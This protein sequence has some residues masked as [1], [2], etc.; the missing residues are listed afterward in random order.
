VTIPRVASA[1]FALAATLGAL[2]PAGLASQDDTPAEDGGPLDGFE[3]LIG[4]WVS[5]ASAQTFE[6]GVG[7][8]VVRARSTVANGDGGRLVSEGMFLH[9]PLREVVR[10]YFVAVEMPAAYF[11]YS[12]RWEGDTLVAHLTTTAPDGRARRYV[13][14]WR[15][16]D[17][18]RIAWT[19]RDGEDE[20]GPVVMTAEFEREVAAPDRAETADDEGT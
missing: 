2:S 14:H 7:R 1:A 19:L 8:L 11:E 6:W 17:P 5:G 13:E 10:G 4:T 9:D 20:S 15:L 12:A 3:R 18:D 16:A